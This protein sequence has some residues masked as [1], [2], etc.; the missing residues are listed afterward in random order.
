MTTRAHRIEAA[1][2]FGKIGR[3]FRLLGRGVRT[4]GHRWLSLLVGLSVAYA[5]W[6]VL[7]SPDF[8]VSIV[9]IRRITPP[10]LAGDNSLVQIQS[11]TGLVG[12]PIFLLDPH[13]VTQQIA[14]LPAVADARLFLVLPSQAI[15]EMAER[16]PEARWI[17]NGHVFL[18]SREGVILGSGDA[19]DLKVTLI[20]DT[21]V[22]LYTGDQVDAKAVEMAFLLRD[23]LSRVGIGT[24]AFRY[25]ALEG[26]S[27]EAEDGWIA[28]YGSADR[29]VEKTQE[30]LTVLRVAQEQQVVVDVVIDLRPSR[31]PTFRTGLQPAGNGT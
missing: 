17:A 10:T 19:P 2:T 28:K 26:L 16:Q 22:P 29:I 11:F 7:T 20:D 24:K 8:H 21:G 31:S 4:F 3:V 18:V 30:L 27:V 15:V 14:Q 1:G 12:Q 6:A 9:A 5:L 25:S 23:L 13:Q